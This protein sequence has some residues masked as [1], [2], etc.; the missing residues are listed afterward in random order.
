[1]DG[2]SQSPRPKCLNNSW[3]K[4]NNDFWSNLGVLCL[5]LKRKL[6]LQLAQYEKGTGHRLVVF[7]GCRVWNNTSL[8]IM[9]FMNVR[10]SAKLRHVKKSQTVYPYTMLSDS[11]VWKNETRL[12]CWQSW[13]KRAYLYLHGII[14]KDLIIAH[15]KQFVLFYKI[16]RTMNFI[17]A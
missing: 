14:A 4:A 15:E 9:N 2:H 1:M 12:F 5:N 13:P 16:M 10:C 17:G 7:I 3:H 8:K 11:S 6:W